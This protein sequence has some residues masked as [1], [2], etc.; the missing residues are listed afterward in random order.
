M[1]ARDPIPRTW[2]HLLSFSIAALMTAHGLQAHAAPAAEATGPEAAPS[3]PAEPDLEVRARARE[4]F[5]QG[6]AKFELADYVGAIALWG[7][8]YEM[9]PF[10]MRDQLHVP[11]ANAHLEAY[12][13]DGDPRHLTQAQAMFEAHLEALDPTDREARANTEAELAKI[14]TELA[15]LEAE[16][17]QR[18]REQIEQE[19]QVREQARSERERQAVQQAQRQEARRQARAREQDR[20]RFRIF[21]GVGGGLAGLGVASL[22]T[23]AA[24][25]SLGEGID[26]Q[27]ADL[28]A[29]P[30]GSTEQFQSLLQ[31]GTTYN[32]LAIATGV[33]GGA[34][35]LSGTTLIVIAALRYRPK[36]SGN[37]ARLRLDLHRME[38]QF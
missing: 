33:L 34:L 37:K 17:A 15:R 10:S 7:Q 38:V 28:M 27:G 6:Q 16:R 1:I 18:A 19:A 36:S 3:A 31:Q 24:G 25:L 26:R 32:R 22:G 9:L 23:M 35:L 29:D 4:L 20:R 14:D 11:L 30:S 21:M 13:A 12:A 5:A 2:L 8:A